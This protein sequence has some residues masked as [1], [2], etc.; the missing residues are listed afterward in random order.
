MLV[1]LGAV[2]SIFGFQPLIFQG[3]S[4][5]KNPSPLV[6]AG[7]WYKGHY[8]TKVM[9]YD[10]N[11]NIMHQYKGNRPKITKISKNAACLIFSSTKMGV[12]F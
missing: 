3:V 6:H 4:A 7:I 5:Q 12:S 10:N 2:T 8:C 11:P 9:K 1:F